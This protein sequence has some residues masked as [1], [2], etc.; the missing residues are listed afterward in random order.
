MANEDDDHKMQGFPDILCTAI[1]I[2]GF[3]QHQHTTSLCLINNQVSHAI[4]CVNLAFPPTC[5]CLCG[6]GRHRLCDRS[7]CAHTH[8]TLC[9]GH[10]GPKTT[11]LAHLAYPPQKDCHTIKSS[12]P[13]DCA[14]IPRRSQHRRRRR[15]YRRDHGWNPRTTQPR[16][17]LISDVLLHDRWRRMLW[18]TCGGCRLCRDLGRF[19]RTGRTC[20]CLCGSRLLQACEYGVATDREAAAL[21]ARLCLG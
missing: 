19:G 3:R 10:A 13:Q 18:S 17:D 14:H 6:P 12:Q 9:T 2:F 7:T 8:K 1:R 4:R 15:R 20:L 11:A 16:P 5:A 21:V